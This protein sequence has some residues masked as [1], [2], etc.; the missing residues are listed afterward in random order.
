MLLVLDVS[1]SMGDRSPAT[2]ATKLDLAKQAAVASLD[3]FKDDDEVGLRIFSTHI[4]GRR[5]VQTDFLDLVP[6]RR[7]G[8]TAS[9]C[10]ERIQDLVPAQRHAA[11]RGDRRPRTRR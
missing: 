6:V 5:D 9:S 2:G 10:A 4:D 8:R 11:L 7:S 1:G 3:Q